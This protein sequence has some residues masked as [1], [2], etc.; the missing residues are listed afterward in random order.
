MLIHFNN[1]HSS[2]SEASSKPSLEASSPSSTYCFDVG[3]LAGG[4]GMFGVERASTRGKYLSTFLASFA[5]SSIWE[6]NWAQFSLLLRNNSKNYKLINTSINTWD[7]K[8]SINTAGFKSSFNKSL[9]INH[10]KIHKISNL[11]IH[12]CR[13]AYAGK[14]FIIISNPLPWFLQRFFEQCCVM[15]DV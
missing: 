2:A 7:F 4:G 8:S 12:H 5:S 11:W 1:T 15:I 10:H 9:F 14:Y 13:H 3:V 6:R